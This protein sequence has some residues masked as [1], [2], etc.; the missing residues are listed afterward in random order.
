MPVG[1]H[2]RANR[3]GFFY[4]D[5]AGHRRYKTGYTNL[6]STRK[7]RDAMK[8]REGQIRD[9]MINPAQEKAKAAAHVPIKTHLDGWE[10]YLKSRGNSGKHVAGRIQM[11]TDVLVNAG[12]DTIA[13]LDADKVQQAIFAAKNKPKGYRARGIDSLNRHV[14]A[15]R[16]FGRWLKA[17]HWA[18]VDPMTPLRL[19][20]ATDATEWG[21][22]TN[23]Q[24][25]ALIVA[26]ETAKDRTR[27]CNIRSKDRAMMYRI[28]FATGFRVKELKSL[29]PESFDLIG[30]TVTVEAAMSK[31]KRR[32]VQDLPASLA[33]LLGPWLGTKTKGRHLFPLPHDTAKMFRRD[34]HRAK[35]GSTDEEGRPFVFHSTRET[36]A[37]QLADAGVEINDAKS[38]MRHSTVT[39]T[40]D[41]Y[42]KV[43]RARTRAAVEKVALAPALA[44]E[45]LS[46]VMLGQ[47]GTEPKIT[48]ET[49]K[50][51]QP[52][53]NTEIT[54]SKDDALSRAR[55]CNR[56]L[57][58]LLVYIAQLVESGKV[59]VSRI[60]TV[61]RRAAL[62]KSNRGR[63]G[64]NKDF[65]PS[66][67]RPARGGVK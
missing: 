13:A 5:H 47:T 59:T 16:Q 11:V 12:I 63:S 31:R 55:T 21:A 7:L 66:P 56:P 41:T 46:W 61:A 14:K 58:R 26:T 35:I 48:T 27:K 1:F 8:D 44:A 32:D 37:T 20:P 40:M 15:C 60:R 17:F 50:N 36:L 18:D 38:V 51:W 65:K 39:L 4:K 23:E 10:A 49:P 34:L 33:G 45:A 29:K 25:A 53:V 30:S 67:S 19:Y 6:D 57:R 24:V 28:A 54:V 64:I 62:G 43:R 22:L 9:G 42:A 2:K 3:W 52:T